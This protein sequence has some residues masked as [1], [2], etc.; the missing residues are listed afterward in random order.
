MNNMNSELTAEVLLNLKERQA[1]AI[2]E[3]M[4][5]KKAAEVST[6]ILRKR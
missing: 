1:V 6:L 4:D 2:L 5:P 3:A